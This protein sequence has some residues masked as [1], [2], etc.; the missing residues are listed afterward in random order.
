MNADVNAAI[1]ILS[2]G[3]REEE[4]CPLD[5]GMGTHPRWRGVRRSYGDEPH[6]RSHQR[7]QNHHAKGNTPAWNPHPL[8][9]GGCQNTYQEMS[10]TWVED[11]SLFSGTFKLH[12]GRGQL[13]KQNVLSPMILSSEN[14]NAND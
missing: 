11:D 4:P 1:N 3:L 5:W 8:G 9:R 7:S 10:C 2:K 6:E 13:F 14:G 12:G